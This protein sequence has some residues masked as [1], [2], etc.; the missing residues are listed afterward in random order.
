MTEGVTDDGKIQ[1]VTIAVGALPV[2]GIVPIG[3]EMEIEAEQF[4][5]AW[6]KPKNAASAKKAKAIVEKRRAEREEEQEKRRLAREMI[7]S[8]GK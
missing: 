7:L 2:T 4:S 5:E 6:M 8:L 1:I 3:T